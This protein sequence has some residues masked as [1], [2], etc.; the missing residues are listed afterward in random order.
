M[1]VKYEI[2]VNVTGHFIS[3]REININLKQGILK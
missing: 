2:S 1:A 3:I